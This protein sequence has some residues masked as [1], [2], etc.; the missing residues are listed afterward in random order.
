MSA[1]GS[2]LKRVRQAAKSRNKNRHYKSILSTA[3]KRVM[4]VDS[5]KDAQSELSKAQKVIDKVAAKGVIH[6]KKAANK[7]SSISKHLN[8]LK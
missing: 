1:K 8:S 5:K 4:N 3:I 6:K 2:V 7:K